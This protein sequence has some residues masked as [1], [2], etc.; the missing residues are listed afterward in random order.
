MHTHTHTHTCRCAGLVS[1]AETEPLLT[2]LHGMCVRRTAHDENEY[3]MTAPLAGGSRRGTFR[4]LK[5]ITSS[6]PLLPLGTA[7]PVM[8]VGRLHMLQMRVRL[9]LQGWLSVLAGLENWSRGACIHTHH[10]VQLWDP[11]DPCCAHV[12]CLLRACML[13]AARMYAAWREEGEPA[14]VP[15][16]LPA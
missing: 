5:R 4:M 11:P 8:C 15:S 16:H 2:L 9:Q 13:P 6:G 1:D 10:C 14:A 7:P 12:C 3:G